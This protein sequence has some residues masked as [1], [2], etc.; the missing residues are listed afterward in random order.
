MEA[1]RRTAALAGIASALALLL[2]SAAPALA[3]HHGIKIREFYPG[4]ASTPQDSFLELQMYAGLQNKT[5]SEI[6]RLFPPGDDPADG[7]FVLTPA[8][9]P[10]NSENQRT[11]LIGGNDNGPANSD[12]RENLDLSPGFNPSGGAICFVSGGIF[13]VIDCVEWGTGNDNVSADPP[14]L[15]GGIP[16]GSSITR[17]IA[18]GC[19][20]FLEASDDT[21]NSAA[22]FALT[23]PTPRGNADPIVETPC[24]LQPPANPPANPTPPKKKAK[25]CKKK[26]KSAQA[27]PRP[28]QRRSARRSELRTEPRLLLVQRLDLL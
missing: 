10:P 3:D 18:P 1:R 13:G 22:D 14:V 5:G 20:T 19:A 6:I 11:I 25:K 4:L 7:D 27:P 12:Y 17:S 2:S 9:D 23:A 28:P 16:N 26:K 24:T 21:N 15:P 8:V